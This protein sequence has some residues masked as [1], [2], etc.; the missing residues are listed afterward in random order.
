MKKNITVLYVEDKPDERRDR[1]FVLSSRYLN[2]IEATNGQN[3]L[4]LYKKHHIDMI[5]TDIMMSPMDGLTMV[6]HIRKIDESLPVYILTGH[7]ENSYLLKAINWNNIHY[8]PKES[9]ATNTLFE[10]SLKKFE[11]YLQDE[12][13]SIYELSLNTYF[14]LLNHTLVIDGYVMPLTTHENELLKL[15]CKK[16]NQVVSYETIH[17]VVWG[18]N[19]EDKS[20][21]RS[22]IRSL[23]RKLKDN[24]IINISGV[25]Y[26]FREL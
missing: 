22:L 20:S 15:F 4:D 14:D 21:A 16:V 25:G 5:I 2:V 1:M 3:G 26:K 24:F 6:E 18:E 11:K 12:S 17:Q 7:L 23:R 10:A 13:S 9:V 19:R 8:V